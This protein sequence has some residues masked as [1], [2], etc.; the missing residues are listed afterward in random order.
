MESKC[1]LKKFLCKSFYINAE[2]NPALPEIDLPPPV[3]AILSPREEPR[4]VNLPSL[5][6]D[7]LCSGEQRAQMKPPEFG[8]S[9]P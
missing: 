1:A 5:Y 2:S 9:S 6:R 8:S 3:H 4:F 7:S